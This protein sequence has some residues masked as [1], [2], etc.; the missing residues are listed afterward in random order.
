MTSSPILQCL[1]QHVARCVTVPRVEVGT[2]PVVELELPD[3]SPPPATLSGTVFFFL[4]FD[5]AAADE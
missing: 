4:P 1:E 2:D 3:S 5:L